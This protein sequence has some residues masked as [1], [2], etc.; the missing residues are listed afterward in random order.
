MGIV[1]AQEVANV[2][3]LKK[4]GTFGTAIGWV[5]LRTTKLSRLNK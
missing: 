5:I 3:N 1:T 4:L 2:M